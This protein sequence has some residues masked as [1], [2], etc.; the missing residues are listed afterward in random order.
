VVGT[1]DFRV[2]ALFIDYLGAES[3]ALQDESGN[4]L[5]HYAV[6]S[7]DDKSIVKLVEKGA[8]LVS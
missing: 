8:N 4:T 1:L 7:L 5:F 6:G 3:L 2:M